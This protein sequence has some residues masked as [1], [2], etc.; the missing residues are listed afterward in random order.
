MVP[1]LACSCFRTTANVKSGVRFIWSTARWKTGVGRTRF[2]SPPDKWYT[3]WCWY[4]CVTVTPWYWD[5]FVCKLSASSRSMPGSSAP[6]GPGNSRMVRIS[7]SNAWTHPQ[8]VSLFQ[9]CLFMAELHE[10]RLPQPVGLL[11]IEILHVEHHHSST[12]PGQVCFFFFWLARGFYSLSFCLV[13]RHA[14]SL[15]TT[16]TLLDFFLLVVMFWFLPLFSSLHHLICRFF[17]ICC[18]FYYFRFFLYFL[19]SPLRFHSLGLLSHLFILWSFCF[20][21]RCIIHESSFR[22]QWDIP[23]SRF[24]LSKFWH[25]FFF[26]FSWERDSS[27]KQLHQ[28]VGLIWLQTHKHW[29]AVVLIFLCWMVRSSNNIRTINYFT[30]IKL[31]LQTSAD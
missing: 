10:S 29:K 17:D 12:A 23:S 4:S 9:R 7:A 15:M 31:L 19:F 16:M 3:L 2:R 30:N 1:E 8:D 27:F 14:A 22:W 5:K 18:F 28:N 25:N 13:S 11:T 26:C 20:M 21:F 24:S 6:P